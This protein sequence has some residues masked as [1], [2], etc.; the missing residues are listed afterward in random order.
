M[1]GAGGVDNR[2]QQTKAPGPQFMDAGA[3]AT[4][5]GWEAGRT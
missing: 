5:G 4:A 1:A 3:V 2:W